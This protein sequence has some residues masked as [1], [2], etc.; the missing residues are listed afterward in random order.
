MGLEQKD[1]EDAAV[2]LDCDVSAI[3]AVVAVESRGTGFDPEGFPLTLFEGHWF[4]KLTAGKYT[5]SHPTISYR[6]W[7][8]AHYGRSWR[9]EKKRL[10]LATSL[11]REAALQS[12]SWG[13]FQIMGANYRE[14]GFDS[15]QEFVNGMILQGESGQLN[16][17]VEFVLSKNLAGFLRNR[18]WAGFAKRY[19]GPQYYVNK[20]DTKL[21][22]AYNKFLNE[23]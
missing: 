18:D 5:A 9:E 6:S 13:L 22:S 2:R 7:T 3:R 11:D 16:A 8:R 10:E 21:A 17:F 4:H 14:C 23:V 1:Y 20:Y 19:N 15:V 12:A